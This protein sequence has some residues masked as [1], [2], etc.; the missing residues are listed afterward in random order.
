[1]VR[2]SVLDATARACAPASAGGMGLSDGGRDG[3]SL[4]AVVDAAPTL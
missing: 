3:S 2:T 4:P 1:L